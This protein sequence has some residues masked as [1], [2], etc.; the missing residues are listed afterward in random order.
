[1]NNCEY[2]DFVLSDEYIES[3]K[4]FFDNT[5]EKIDI[6]LGAYLGVIDT[7]C[8]GGMIE[9]KTGDVLKEFNEKARALENLATELGSTASAKLNAFLKYVDDTDK[10][11][12]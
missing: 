8:N 12:Y 1:M 5:A 4:T 10:E 2:Y 11:I 3:M 9:G 7:I 6:I